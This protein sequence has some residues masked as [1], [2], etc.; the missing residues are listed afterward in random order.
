MFMEKRFIELV[1]KY[2]LESKYAD[3]AFYVEFFN[4]AKECLGLEN[5][6]SNLIF[7]KKKNLEILSIK[8]T[9]VV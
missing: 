9:L 8:N 1:S 4:I 7:I 2:N 5:Y 3:E 6:L